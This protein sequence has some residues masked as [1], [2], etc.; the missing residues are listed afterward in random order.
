VPSESSSAQP[1]SAARA[2][3]TTRPLDEVA[4]L[5][6]LSHDALFVSHPERD[7]ELWNGAAAA[8]YGFTR[9]EALG[10]TPRELLATRAGGDGAE[11]EM[12]ASL[13]AWGRWEGVLERRAKDGGSLTVAVRLQR[14][15]GVDGVE[16]VL[17]ADRDETARA[18]AE[19]EIVQRERRLRSFVEHTPAPVA[20][21][22]REMRYVV[23][24]RRWLSDYRLAEKDL[25]G[26]S[27]YDVFPGLPERWREIHRRCL[28]GA[29]ERAEEDSFV[30]AD[31]TTDWLRWEV[32]PW[33][34]ADGTIGGIIVFSELITER[35]Q[36]ELERERLL[37]ELRRRAGELEA[38]IEAVADG[39]IVVGP[40]GEIAAASARAKDILGVVNG[41][42]RERAPG[43]VAVVRPQTREGVE[44][45]FEATPSAPALR[46]E[47]VRDEILRV[48]R[49]DGRHVW[50]SSSAAPIVIDG[51]L[52]GAVVTFVDVTTRLEFERTLRESEEH[53]RALAEAMPQ[54]VW[55]AASDG[56]ATFLNRQ[57]VEFTGRVTA[58]AEE[59]RELIHPDDR[60]RVRDAWNEALRARRDFECEYRF[61]R[62]DGAYR[63]L[64]TRAHPWRSE[65]GELLQWFGT[66]TDVQD[67]KALSEALREADARK[68]DFLAVLSHELRT[69]LTPIR[70]AVA[71][72]DRAEPGGDSARSALRIIDRQS[73]HL[74]RLIDDLLDVTRITRGK[75]ALRREPVQLGELVR[76]VT[77]DYA[78]IFAASEVALSADLGDEPLWVD[79][80]PTRLAQI[81]G[82]LLKNAAKFTQAGGH[83]RIELA[84]GRAGDAALLCVRDDGLGITA[85]LLPRLFV[86]FMQADRTLDRSRGGLGLG[87]A[88][89]KGLVELHGGKVSVA[90][91]G[92]AAG[93]V[94]TVRLPRIAPPARAT[95][96]TPPRLVAGGPSP[97][98]AR[99]LVI[100]DNEDAAESLQEALRY[101][102]HEVEVAL[103]GLAG[104]RKALALVPD[105]VLCDLGLPGIDGYEVARR[106]KREPTLAR[107]LLVALSGYA[108]PDDVRRSLEAGFARHVAKPPDLDALDALVAS[109][110]PGR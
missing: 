14:L 94:L 90:S 67:L 51:R 61:R 93:T 95:T 65:R 81:V 6:E 77:E 91:D 36:A 5:L 110:A 56:N 27:H 31:G 50:L 29:V 8:L 44:L 68:D 23:V 46:G 78:S 82:N 11:A 98:H 16:R 85:E 18:H 70:N 34:E 73:E 2:T 87:L 30:R 28:A 15:R 7:I 79:G 76:R 55:V 53:F 39:L 33:H 49:P 105:V 62:F 86:P 72:L 106:L 102:G 54:L 1:S 66:A 25:V 99:V 9:D 40:S 63:W 22:D 109:A 32:H 38:T 104:V 4:A 58:T 75:I 43:R 103:D 100:E 83:T 41:L 60:S 101:S 74:R 84:A 12:E 45:A 69:P 3:S 88:L 13:R 19:A 96:P 10:R 97:S 24:S 42:F 108:R 92:P 107:C 80:D 20:M 35:K 47:T 37:V 48:T 57:W 17:E 26:K 89:V 52:S 71:V 64:L 59:R 21:L